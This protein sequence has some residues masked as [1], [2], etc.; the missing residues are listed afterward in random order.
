MKKDD[1]GS[2]FPGVMEMNSEFNF[3]TN[4]MTLRDYFAGQAL[5]SLRS[6]YERDGKTGARN[7]EIRQTMETC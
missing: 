5:L 7:C 2:A 4:G 3:N 6:G 1:G